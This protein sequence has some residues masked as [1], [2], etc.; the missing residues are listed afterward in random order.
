MKKQVGRDDSKL[1]RWKFYTYPLTRAH[2]G[3]CSDL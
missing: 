1:E 3:P 2:F